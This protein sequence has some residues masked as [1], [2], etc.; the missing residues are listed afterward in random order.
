MTPLISSVGQKTDSISK[1]HNSRSRCQ[2]LAIL[3]FPVRS[4]HHLQ[5]VCSVFSQIPASTKEKTL[6]C[7]NYPWLH[8][9]G[10][11]PV[12]RPCHAQPKSTSPDSKDVVE[13]HCDLS[14]L[15]ISWF[16]GWDNNR[17]KFS[18]SHPHSDL[19]QLRAP[20]ILPAKIWSSTP[21]FTI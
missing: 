14:T 2:T 17:G 19:D 1:D 4:V 10:Q 9:L 18:N 12:E 7:T 3:P 6:K 21:N 16:L 20:S 13:G 8:L 5:P 15:T 11:P